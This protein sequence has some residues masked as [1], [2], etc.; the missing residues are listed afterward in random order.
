ML[1]INLFDGNFSHTLQEHGFI[2][3]TFRIKPSKVEWIPKL[4][5][6]DGI[7]IFTDGY[8][9]D[10]I[11]DEVKSKIKIF[12]AIESR[13]IDPEM[14]TSL[15]KNSHKFDYIL[16]HDEELLKLGDKYILYVVGQSRVSDDEAR[17][18]KKSKLTSMISSYKT[19]TEGHRFRHQIIQALA[20]KHQFDVWGSG[21]RP[22]EEKVEALSDYCFSISVI[23]CKRKDYFTEVLLDN[24]RVGTV[25][26]L[27]GLPN[28]EDYFDVGGV[29][30][31]DTLEELDNILENLS[32]DDYISRASAIKR[33]FEL[34]KKYICTDDIVADTLI[35][36][37]KL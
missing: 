9:N 36:K 3:S 18:Y 7:T 14:Y 5:E 24:F 33:N 32:I 35:D 19:M 25:P 27:W 30:T 12:W 23:N 10:L 37:L 28:V 8:V 4:M 1:R 16:T 29:I 2:T 31:F 20:S 17:F 34:V 26:I 11:V 6:Y 15:I 21:Y 13:S 22:F